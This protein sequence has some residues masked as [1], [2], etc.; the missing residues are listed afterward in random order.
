MRESNLTRDD[1]IE[2][3]KIAQTPKGPMR[4]MPYKERKAR[5]EDQKWRIVQDTRGGS[6]SVPTKAYP[7]YEQR[8]AEKPDPPAQPQTSSAS[9]SSTSWNTNQWWDQTWSATSWDKHKN[10]ERRW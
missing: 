4:G 1:M 6:A 2:Y 7:N 5:F 8:L 10:W 3:D 9:S